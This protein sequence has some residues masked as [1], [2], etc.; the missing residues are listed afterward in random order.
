MFPNLT[1]DEREYYIQLEENA[2][3]NQVVLCLDRIILLRCPLDAP[4]KGREEDALVTELSDWLVRF[5]RAVEVDMQLRNKI[6]NTIAD[7]VHESITLHLEYLRQL[8]KE[9]DILPQTNL[10]SDSIGRR[11]LVDSYVYNNLQQMIGLRLGVKPT[12]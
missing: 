9:L 2:V 4:P 12:N 7:M 6:A 8:R 10:V 11:G 1:K 3:F 5:V